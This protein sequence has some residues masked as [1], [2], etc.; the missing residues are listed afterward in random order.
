M[1]KSSIRFFL[2]STYTS[3]YGNGTF[4]SLKLRYRYFCLITC[5]HIFL[6]EKEGEERKTMDGLKAKLMDRCKHATFKVSSGQSSL[7][8]E[9]VLL[10]SNNPVICIDQVLTTV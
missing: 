7:T 3:C 2:H 1:Y 10:D 5:I 6:T 8:A 9:D 4:V